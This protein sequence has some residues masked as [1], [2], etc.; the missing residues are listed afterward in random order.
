MALRFETLRA[1]LM[2]TIVSLF[3]GRWWCQ[4]AESLFDGFHRN[5]E[6]LRQP[7]DS[8]EFVMEV[9]LARPI[10]VCL[11]DDT[12][13]GHLQGIFPAP[14]EGVHQEQTALLLTS[15][16]LAHCQSAQQSRRKQRVPGQ[17]LCDVLGKFFQPHRIGGKCVI[18]ENRAAGA[19]HYKRG[20]NLTSGVMARLLL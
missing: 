16:L 19:G 15:M 18:S 3:S 7:G 17:T 1:S 20:R 2:E 8:N 12:H 6:L 13:G 4:L 14:V 5:E 9:K 10:V 11:G